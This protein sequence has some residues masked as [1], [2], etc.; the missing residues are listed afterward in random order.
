MTGDDFTKIFLDG[1]SVEQYLR[2]PLTRTCFA[3]YR[4]CYLNLFSLGEIEVECGLNFLI[5][6]PFEI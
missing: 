4:F 5:N 3:G 6:L 2:R 1:C